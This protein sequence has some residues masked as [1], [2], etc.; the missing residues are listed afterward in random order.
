MKAAEAAGFNED[1]IIREQIQKAKQSYKP[2]ANAAG[3][4]G[5]YATA[6]NQSTEL[7]SQVKNILDIPT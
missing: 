3:R 1:P 2:Q 5:M 7:A 4:Q 6:A